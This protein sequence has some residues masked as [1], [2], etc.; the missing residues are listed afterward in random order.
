MVGANRIFEWLGF[1]L[2]HTSVGIFDMEFSYG[3]HGDALSGIV[4]VNAGNSAGLQLK[5]RIPVG[6][7]YYSADEVDDIAEY[8]GDFWHGKDYD[9]FSKNCNDFTERFISY[10]CDFERFY[11]PS[12]INRF[13]KLGSVLRM[14]FKP[15]QEIIGDIVD[16]RGMENNFEESIVALSPEEE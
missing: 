12:Y 14:W 13:C 11:V 16:Y 4:V 8:F 6:V 5:E 15:L 2:Y 1:G 9:P 3:G 10:I 7:T